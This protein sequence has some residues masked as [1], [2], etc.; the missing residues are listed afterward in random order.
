MAF[1]QQG[2]QGEKG[3]IAKGFVELGRMDR[4]RGH[5]P[6][7]QKTQGAV[8][9]KGWG[10]GRE[11]YADEALGWRAK[12][13]A[14]EKTAQPPT[15]YIQIS[16]HSD[17]T[18]DIVLKQQKQGNERPE[19]LPNRAALLKKLSALHAKNPKAA[20]LIAADKE[21]RYDEVIQLISEAKK[22]GIERVGLA[23]K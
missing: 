16:L 9:Q 1:G 12:A 23:T 4:Q 18:L 21:A 14:A 22:L 11:A 13:A 3:Q 15:E 8:L 10:A 7:R 19:K 20:V 5:G 6:V 17:T 2:Q